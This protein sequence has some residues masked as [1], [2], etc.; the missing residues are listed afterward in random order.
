MF[1]DVWMVMRSG[2]RAE[3]GSEK[4]LKRGLMVFVRAYRNSR[5]MS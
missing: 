4:K 5:E 3:R 1:K 2:K